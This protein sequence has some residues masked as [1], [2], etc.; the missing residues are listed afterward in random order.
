M[1]AHVKP[2]KKSSKNVPTFRVNDLYREQR[3]CLCTELFLYFMSHYYS[4]IFYL[5]FDFTKII[6]VLERHVID[7]WYV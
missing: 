2:I 5:N 1:I 4:L 6:E 3:L 7:S